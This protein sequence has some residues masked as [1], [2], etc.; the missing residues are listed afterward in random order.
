MQIRTMTLFAAS[1]KDAPFLLIKQNAYKKQKSNRH[2]I[3]ACFIKRHEFF[4]VL[5][6]GG[7]KQL[8]LS[9]GI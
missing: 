9:C 1:V 2:F 6:E 8:K 7:A 3:E 4:L 5:S